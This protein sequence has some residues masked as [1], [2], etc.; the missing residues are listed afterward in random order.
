MQYFIQF[1]TVKINSASLTV[2]M[3]ETFED[4]STEDLADELPT[5]QPR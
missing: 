1:H 2:E 5:A 3:D 4:V